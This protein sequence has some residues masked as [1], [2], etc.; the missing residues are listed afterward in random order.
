[1]FEHLDAARLARSRGAYGVADHVLAD[2]HALTGARANAVL[3]ELA[4]AVFHQDQFCETTPLV[5]PYFLELLQ[6]DLPVRTELTLVVGSMLPNTEGHFLPGER[7]EPYVDENGVATAA[8]IRA[9][10]E[11]FAA[12]LDAEPSALRAAAAWT[13]SRV[14]PEASDALVRSL[15]IETDEDARVSMLI[16]IATLR[17]ASEQQE[18]AGSRAADI[19]RVLATRAPMDDAAAEA[20][21][22]L[23][24]APPWPTLHVDDGLPTQ[25]AVRHLLRLGPEKPRRFTLL[26]D[27]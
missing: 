19:A 17:Q 26:R 20:F 5:I 8:A 25:L 23:L 27:A 14:G 22:C 2:L 1:M 10:R 11:V 24:T 3:G 15:A 16:A 21:T 13:L 6:H 9:G 4:N 18:E 12:L 7:P